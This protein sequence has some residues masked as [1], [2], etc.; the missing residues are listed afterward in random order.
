MRLRKST[1]RGVTTA[2]AVALLAAAS[3][4]A[5]SAAA[6]DSDEKTLTAD[7]LATWQTDG[8]VWSLE[9][10][11]GVVYVGGSFDKV[12]PPG[13][14]PGQREVARKNFAAFDARTGRLLPCALP[15]TGGGS[16][17]R[18]LKMSPADEVLYVGGSFSRVGKNRATGAAAVNT[19]NCS[20]RKDFRPAISSYV[21]AIEVTDSAVYLGGDFTRVNGKERE[22]VAALTPSGS[23][24]PFRAEI[25]GPVRA[26]LA[27]PEFGKLIVGGN[28]NMVNDDLARSLVALRPA[29]GKTVLTYSDWLPSRSSVQALTRD[30][31]NFYVAAEGRGTGIFDGRIAGRLGGGEMV[32][33]DTCLGATQAVAVYNGVL[34]SGSHAHNCSDTPGGFDEGNFRQHF[35]AQSV[36]D[37]HILHWFPDTD[38]G[39][40]E[41]NGPRALKMAGRILWAGG[42]FTEVNGRR[43]QSLTRFTTGPDRGTPEEPPRLKASASRTGRVTLSWRSAWDRDDAVLTYR[44]Y[45]DGKLV[46]SPTGR[47]TEWNRPTMKYTDTVTPGSR[48]RYRIAVT[49]GTNTAPASKALVVTAAGPERTKA[50][51]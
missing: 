46:A 21:R 13:A 11:N 43:Q 16:V 34:Y 10:A 50:K 27:A 20:L 19:G 48:H 15:F 30:A 45:R 24:L 47:S 31:T 28:F 33:K 41:G 17:V 38:G 32:W 5:A 22:R 42:E 35:L 18:A 26:L 9:Y 1:K 7:T 40:G 29:T 49:D 51:R 6:A 8:I 44:I 36:R 14:K 12:R 2:S 3:L 23:L 4:I 25:D 39:T 37:R